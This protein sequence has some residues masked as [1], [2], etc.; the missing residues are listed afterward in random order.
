MLAEITGRGTV[1]IS[2][3][4]G[5]EL[6]FRSQ[7]CLDTVSPSSLFWFYVPV[8]SVLLPLPKP[9]TVAACQNAAWQDP[10][11][12]LRV[13]L[14]VPLTGREG[15]GMKDWKF[16]LGV[17]VLGW[18]NHPR[19]PDCQ[20]LAASLC[21]RVLGRGEQN[22]PDMC[23]QGFKQ[24]TDSTFKIFVQILGPSEII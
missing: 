23:G 1:P 9:P 22:I 20:P 5:R 7:R 10:W 6:C 14:L 8:M 17:T 4:S 18:L 2:D 12:S 21:W 3:S 24:K 15:G 16:A 19:K 13:L 11:R